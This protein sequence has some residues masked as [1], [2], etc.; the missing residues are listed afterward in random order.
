LAILVFTCPYGRTETF[1]VQ[2]Q[3]TLF[4]ESKDWSGALPNLLKQVQVLLCAEWQKVENRE[5]VAEKRQVGACSI[6]L[7]GSEFSDFDDELKLAL[8][9]EG[10]RG[11][12]E[13]SS[14][15]MA[16]LLMVASRRLGR[17]ILVVRSIAPD[18]CG[19]VPPHPDDEP[20]VVGGCTGFSYDPKVT[21]VAIDGIQDLLSNVRRMTRTTGHEVGH[22][23]GLIDL[24]E[25]RD[26]S[27]L[28]YWKD[29]RNS[30]ALLHGGQN[31]EAEKIN[32]VFGQPR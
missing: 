14:A 20:L 30:G 24:Y 15:R 2:V 6:S 3:P 16:R 25:D 10:N 17:T 31:G 23:A 7:S 13:I 18:A 29:W 11:Q 26:K 22:R 9:V 28:M 8:G 19:Y 12:D 1:R 4:R 5:S 27:F 21:L 32:K